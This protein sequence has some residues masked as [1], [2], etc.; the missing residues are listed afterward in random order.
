[1][2][3]PVR[4]SDPP[5]PGNAAKA[6]PDEDQAIVVTGVKRQAG[7]IL[8]GVSVLDEEELAHDMKPSIGDTLADLPGSA[9]QASD[10]RRRARSCAANP[11]ER[12]RC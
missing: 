4:D 7:D 11:G 6:H 8:G 2:T 12:V 10:R 9:R 1:M 3:T 5:V